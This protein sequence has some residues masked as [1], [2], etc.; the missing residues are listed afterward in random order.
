MGTLF[1]SPAYYSNP[2]VE[3]VASVVKSQSRQAFIHTG[4]SPFSG[5]S[6]NVS[7]RAQY[8]AL[9]T[10]PLRWQYDEYFKDTIV[11]NICIENGDVLSNY[12]RYI[13]NPANWLFGCP[14]WKISTTTTITNAAVTK[15]D[16]YGRPFTILLTLHGDSAEGVQVFVF[17]SPN[18]VLNITQ[19]A[20]I[21]ASRLVSGTDTKAVLNL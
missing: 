17:G 2:N 10:L 7:N 5:A 21:L 9:Q 11:K 12:K 13:Y 18:G 8:T 3:S 4:D 14:F 15:S 20:D 6:N 19:S 16:L 1:G